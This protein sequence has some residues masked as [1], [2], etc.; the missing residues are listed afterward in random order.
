MNATH[1]FI[2]QWKRKSSQSSS[3]CPVRWPAHQ[4]HTRFHLSVKTFKFAVLNLLSGQV[5]S[6][7]VPHTFPSLSED[8]QVRSPQATVQS[9]D[10]PISATHVSISQ[11]RR[12][13]LQSWSCCPVRWPAHQYYTRFHLLVKTLK[14]AVLK[15]LSSQ[16]TSPSVP[17]TF[18]STLRVC[19]P[20]PSKYIAN[21]CG[22]PS[23]QVH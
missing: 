19:S 6:P 11:W 21:C 9:N 20:H 22:I 14:F 18:L 2:S 4:C 7:S 8:A 12:S 17:Y 5:T 1:V 10:Q 13:S 23:L 3:C 16:V 15:L